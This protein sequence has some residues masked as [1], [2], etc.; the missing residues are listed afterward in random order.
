MTTQQNEELPIVSFLE[1]KK[2]LYE[3]HQDI[4]EN[5]EDEYT[6]KVGAETIEVLLPDIR[7]LE[8]SSIDKAKEE[9]RERIVGI[10]EYMKKKAEIKNWK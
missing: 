5:E 8:Q 1:K 9:E 3:I 10:L 6:L 4:V 2:E 7:T